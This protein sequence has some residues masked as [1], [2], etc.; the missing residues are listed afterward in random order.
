MSDIG[1]SDSVE[2]IIPPNHSAPQDTTVE[3][4]SHWGA[5][6]QV[7]YFFGQRLLYSILVLLAIIFLTYFGL[8]MA[9]GTDFGDSLQEA[10]AQTVE[11][12]GNLLQGDLG[13]ATAASSNVRPRPMGEVI[14]ERMSRSLGLLFISMTLATV[15]GVTLGMRAARSGS[16]HSLGII[17]T[18]IIGVSVPAFFAAFLLQWALTS[19]TRW[20]GKAL[21]PVGGYGWDEHLILPVIVLAARPLAQITRISFVSLRDVLS[22]DYV[23][24]ARAKGLRKYQVRWSHVMRNAAIPILTVVGISFRFALSTLVVV[25]FYFGW[26]GAGFTLLKSIS[27]QDD[28]LTVTFVLLLGLLIVLFN[29]ILE[30]VY[31]LI[32]PR[33]WQPPSH[34]MENSQQSFGDSLRSFGTS[35]RNVAVDNRI[36]RWVK[37]R[38]EPDSSAATRLGLAQ[39]KGTDSEL[40]EP[41]IGKRSVWVALRRNGPFS[42]GGLLVLGLAVIVI[43]GPFMSP[44]NPYSTQGLMTVDGVLTRPPLP[45]SETYPWGTDALGRDMLSL[46]LSGAQQTLML[47][48]VVV[49]ARFILGVLLGAI[50]G[51]RNGSRLDRAILGLAEVIAAFPNLLLA[52]ILIL[53]LGIRQGMSTFLIALGFIG[54]GEI[55]QFVRSKV[56]ALRGEQFVESAVA[57]GAGTTRIIN[58]HIMPNLFG[59]LISL[60]ALEMGAVLLLLGELGYLSIFVGGGSMIE[61]PGVPPQLFSDVP[62]W[63]A[64]LSN[65]RY[66]ARAYPWTGFYT[67]AAFFLA[68]FAFNL[69]GEGVRRAV[70]SGHLIISRFVNRYSVALVVLGILFF[71]WFQA[72]S[73]AMPFYRELAQPFDGEMALAHVTALTEPEMDGRSL[74]T[75]G[76][77]TAAQYIAEQMEAYGLQTGGESATYYQERKHSFGRLESKPVLKFNDGGPP[78]VYGKDY[79]A[80]P[81]LNMTAGEAN[82][83]ITIVGVGKPAPSGSTGWRTSYPELDR[84]DFSDDILLAVS[85]YNGRIL[86]WRTEHAGLLVVVDDPA[87]LAEAHTLSGRTGQHLNLFT[88]ELS[89]EETPAIWISEETG[90][91]LLASSGFTVEDMGERFDELAPE[92][93]FEE[94]LQVSVSMEVQGTL[95]EKFPVQHVIGYRPGDFGYELCADCLDKEIVVV[96]AQYDTPPPGPNGE[97]SPAANDNASGVAVMLEAIRVLDE[98]DYQPRRS[99]LFIA[100]SGEGLDGGEPVNDP[101]VKRFLQAKTGFIGRF[102]PVA[103]VQLRGL[104][105]GTGDRLEVS[106]SGSLRLADLFET[107]AKQT[108]VRPVRSEEAIDISLIYEEVNASADSSGKQAPVVRLY[109]EGWDETSRLPEDTLEQIS[110]EN[111]QKAGRTLAMALMALGREIEY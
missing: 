5:L 56:A 88:G 39:E 13:M 42:V 52:M 20:A 27:Q 23:R 10:A 2:S 14:I 29:F 41:F 73:G 70:E 22:Q 78:L 31:R 69:F 103:I 108:G 32:D 102:E 11:Y 111:L 64:L 62:E 86:S 71:N 9:G 37:R 21:L 24:T 106:A 107:A 26:Q 51:W 94:P 67:M 93:V 87:K 84:V 95:E 40:D 89:G 90:D 76:Q 6:A 36:A 38:R 81:G 8:S 79:S 4:T 50:A 83:S 49:A 75:P 77:A 110:E 54:W 55:M 82:G 96:M 65:I 19:Y 72:N 80:Y 63:G 16:K 12:V 58:T 35:L 104:G 105:D 53:A 85:D 3:V 44:H 68:I 98:A 59:S 17:L 100:Y 60:I 25:E 33:L 74:G 97:F 47:V 91:R 15:L 57:S 92:S 46:I 99:F 61:L 34:V 45:P 1:F 18:T 66:Q 109:W 30:F 28:N 101:D 43:L 7:L 48:I